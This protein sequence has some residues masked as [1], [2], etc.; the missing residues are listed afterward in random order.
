MGRVRP[1]VGLW[2]PVLLGAL[3]TES[4]QEKTFPLRAGWECYSSFGHFNISLILSNFS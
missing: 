4:T 1:G 3:Q 2:A